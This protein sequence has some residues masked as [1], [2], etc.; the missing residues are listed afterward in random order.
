MKGQPC[1]AIPPFRFLRTGNYEDLLVKFSIV[2][3]L[4][5]QN[6]DISSYC[7]NPD[8]SSSPIPFGSSSILGADRKRAANMGSKFGYKDSEIF[9]CVQVISHTTA[10]PFD[11]SR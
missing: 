4:A 3:L 11:S 5:S 7:S 6:N 8:D 1:L 9:D 2:L 10:S